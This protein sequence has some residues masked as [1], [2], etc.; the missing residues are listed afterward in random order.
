MA[1]Y[2]ASALSEVVQSFFRLDDDH[3]GLYSVLVG[4]CAYL[5]FDDSVLE[6]AMADWLDKRGACKAGDLTG[7]ECKN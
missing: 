6:E 3:Y 7:K 1:D 4:D 5:E 2:G